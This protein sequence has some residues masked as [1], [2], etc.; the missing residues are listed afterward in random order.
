[1]NNSRSKEI[2]PSESESALARIL[3]TPISVRAAIEIAVDRANAEARVK[4]LEADLIVKHGLL[5][6]K[7]R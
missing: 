2:V 4:I 1:M 5:R 3:E 7:K 6:K